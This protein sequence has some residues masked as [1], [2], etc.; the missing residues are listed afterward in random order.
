MVPQPCPNG[1]FTPPDLRGLKEE[2]E[3]LPCPPGHF[4]R[5][6]RILGHCAAG[7]LCVLGSSEA[8]PQG[9][10]LD[11]SSQCGWGVQCAGP[12]PAGFYCVEGAEEPQACPSQTVRAA[13]GATM[14]QDCLPCPPR[15]W[16]R[17]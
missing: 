8:T 1:T 5:S 11:N 7:Y 3:C 6:G 17:E 10:L 13:P 9:L 14:R 16:C 15:H 12:C 2:G 4:C